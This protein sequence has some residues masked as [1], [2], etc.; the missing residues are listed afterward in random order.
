MKNFFKKLSFVLAIAMVLTSLAPATASAAAK[1]YITDSR[2]G[3]KVTSIY[4]YVGGAEATLTPYV[5]GKKASKAIVESSNPERA[6]I[7]KTGKI[8]PV[9]NGNT[10]ITFTQGKK[11]I[12]KVTVKVRTRAKALNIYDRAE[13]AAGKKEKLSE[14][15]LKVGEKKD[16]QITMPISKAAKK[17]VKKSTYF[18]YAEYDSSVVKVN[19]LGNGQRH[20]EVEAVAAGTTKVTIVAN[21]K[22][23]KNVR[24]DKYYKEASFNVTV[25]EEDAF[26]AKQTGV[27]KITVT[28]KDLTAE[29]KD[30]TLKRGTVAVS[31]EK[32]EL[33][34]D[35]TKAVLVAASAK[36]P[37]GDYVV[38]F[39]ALTSESFKVEDG[40]LANFEVS[41][42]L[43]LDGDYGTASSAT[44]AYKA[45]NQFEED[46]T[47]TTTN[48]NVSCT[49]GT[50]ANGAPDAAHSII[51]VTNISTFY[52]VG[53]T[54]KIYII[55]TDGTG[56]TKEAEVVLSGKKQPAD[57]SVLGV[58]DTNSKKYV[59]LKANTD[60]TKTSLVLVVSV[61][62]QYDLP[63]AGTFDNSVCSIIPN[64]VLTGFS[65]D[66]DTNGA[67]K[68]AAGANP[69][70]YVIEIAEGKYA[71]GTV[72]FTFV[73]KNSVAKSNNIAQTIEI[74]ATQK[75]A[76]IDVTPHDSV[77]YGEKAAF[78]Y[79]ALDQDG[80][81]ITSVD[82]LNDP[83][84]GVSLPA[85][86][87][88]TDANYD[89]VAELTFD[90]ANA[91]A[92]VQNPTEGLSNLYSGLAMTNDYSFNKMITFQYGAEAHPQY[93]NG[94]TATTTLG[95]IGTG[96]S[97]TIGLD[98]LVIAD[99][100]GRVMTNAKAFT[101]YAVTAS[102]ANAKYTAVSNSASS[103]V[104]GSN[105]KIDIKFADEF[106]GDAWK[107]T[108]YK[109]GKEV[110]G[111]S[112][113]VNIVSAD[114][115]DLVKFEASCEGAIYRG[116]ST[117]ATN[118][119]T[120]ISVV[121]YN[122]DGVKFALTNQFNVVS[123]LVADGDVTV[124]SASA[125]AVGYGAGQV[126]EK[127]YDVKVAIK[128]SDGT[129][130]NKTVTVKAAA[131]V[132]A[133]ISVPGS[134]G[135]VKVASGSA[136]SA[137]LGKEIA[138]QLLV[139]DQYGY[140]MGPKN[141]NFEA[142]HLKNVYLYDSENAALKFTNNNTTGA[143][144]STA[145]YAN[146][147]AKLTFDNGEVFTVKVIFE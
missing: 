137:D 85:G 58:F 17:V 131:P 54:G 72:T 41:E 96:S 34:E 20:F 133:S 143:C 107:L 6:T 32:V 52:Q 23:E 115:A 75:V 55:A 7:D 57:V 64:A 31:V 91:G 14:V 25:K 80:K 50:V 11:T 77:Y 26:S 22:T 37:A 24:A 121:G 139:V 8:T 60:Y 74:G 145:T 142:A 101:D 49:L 65:L 130:I 13:Y 76:S 36:Y 51:K 70:E 104:F 38:T 129:I 127:A 84:Y 78:D 132:V 119:T 83:K 102:A 82:L 114:L 126:A 95:K 61:K 3:K 59:D 56:V 128:N 2:T 10:T 18:T 35:K 111:A 90:F 29:V 44:I 138:G 5:N 67:Y 27:K 68:S 12:G 136:D 47:S 86:F 30:Y 16:L 81:E 15:T 140:K 42:Y 19:K 9:A 147:M 118:K 87:A 100:Y 63:Y 134:V 120:D 98:N 112:K 89:G 33:S 99:Q 122:R 4:V 39:G 116:D 46:I 110:T 45:L 71:A 113:S 103:F 123:D 53:T 106:G 94:V 62:D 69:G 40:K 117:V 105:D 93:I 66:T 135:Y 108:L 141:N 144:F 97:I 79:T 21:Q 43:V 124:N 88:F 1:N 28:G 48:V 125:S 146:C 73:L 109:D 92:T